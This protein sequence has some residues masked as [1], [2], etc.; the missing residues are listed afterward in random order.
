MCPGG[1]GHVTGG[2]DSLT[3]VWM[4]TQGDGTLG[5]GDPTA[6]LSASCPG[7]GSFWDWGADGGLVGMKVKQRG[8]VTSQSGSPWMGQR[9]GSRCGLCGH[10]LGQGGVARAL[11]WCKGPATELRLEPDPRGMQAVS[12]PPA[13]SLPTTSA[14]TG[15]SHFPGLFAWG[16]RGVHICPVKQDTSAQSTPCS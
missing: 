14:R 16:G 6:V 9:S 7:W 2:G 8:K 13:T 11:W 3:R 15:Q 10:C 12:C 1:L 4:G 5:L